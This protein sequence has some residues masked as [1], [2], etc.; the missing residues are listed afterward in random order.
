MH[1]PYILR[2]IPDPGTIN[3]ALLGLCARARAGLVIAALFCIVLVTGRHAERIGDVVQVALP[4]AG[5]GCAIGSGQG[6]TYFG[7]YI[8]LEIGIKTPK[9]LLG[10][11]PINMRPDG[12]TAGFPSG[13]TAAATFG[14]TGLMQTCLK[15]SKPAQAV[16]VLA[17]GFTG[18]SRIDAGK[19]N[20][21]QVLAGATLGWALQVMAL[22][23]FERFCRRAWTRLGRFVAGLRRRPNRSS[24]GQPSL[25]TILVLGLLILPHS[26]QAEIEI[27]GY[28]GY[29]TAGESDVTGTDP[30][31]AGAFD[32]DA[33][34]VGRSFDA[35]PY[36]GVRATAWRSERVGWSVE[37]T[38]AKILADDATLAGSGFA[39]LEFTDG[40][41]VATL[42]P[43]WRFPRDAS[44]WTP[45]AGFGFGFGFPHVEVRTQPGA[46][47]TEGYQITGPALGWHG[48]LRYAID[49]QWAVFGEYKGNYAWIDADLDGGGRLKTEVDTHAIN[50]GVSFTFD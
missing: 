17:A 27:S 34:W 9:F 5:L 30:A 13:H 36:Y 37:F 16:V 11:H 33:G 18:G 24:R 20:V 3:R 31:G 19:H 48:G 35:P 6:V 29:Q 47:L 44:R 28:V 46:P 41:N 1:V 22:V 26:G 42:G 25:P 7:R 32:F 40:L 10:E 50:F 38:H 14:A 2:C 39:K 12:G 15:S 45:Y 8:L 23:R 4:V 43:S 21:W 49:D